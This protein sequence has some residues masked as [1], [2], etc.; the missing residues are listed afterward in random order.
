MLINVVKVAIV[1]KVATF[2]MKYRADLSERDANYANYAA[3]TANAADS[4]V[5]FVWS[6]AMVLSD[7]QASA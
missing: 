3:N 2:P 1:A 5:V 4:E 6:A 7:A